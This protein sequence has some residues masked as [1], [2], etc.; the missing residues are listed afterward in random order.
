MRIS[1]PEVRRKR[2]LAGAVAALAIVAG[3][4]A[5]AASAP[6]PVKN[7]PKN[8]VGPAAGDDWFAWSQSREKNTSPLDLYAQQTGHAAFRVNPKNT[9]AYA[10]GID[11]TNL[12]Y[13]LIR[14]NLATRSDLR[15]YDLTTRRLEPLPSGIN[16]P[17]W[18]CCGTISGG[19]VLFSRGQVYTNA[20]QL[21]ILRNLTTGEQRVLDA[22]RNRKGL[23]SAGQLNGTF[24]VWARCNPY[25]RCGIYRYDLATSSA[26]PLT[27]PAG[28]VPYS[29]SVD[30]RG[31]V[32][33]GLSNEGCGKSVQLV[34]QP[35]E[36]GPEVLATL[37][38]GKDLDVTYAHTVALKPPRDDITTRVYYDIVRCR[39][40][41]WNIYSVDDTIRLPPR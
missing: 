11:G 36:G 1:A 37:A 40:H 6:V 3:S 16:T 14:G 18:E 10:G 5:L 12:L 4:V 34:K 7:G 33:Y 35:V 13:Q 27:I 30:E 41:R 29:P 17:K 20:T 28:K 38:Q 32:Y 39:T 21:V 31:T 15:L 24:A 23:L 25:P 2:I 22:L 8:E 9:Q 26:T 19:W